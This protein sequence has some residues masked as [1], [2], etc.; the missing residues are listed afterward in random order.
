ME[1]ISIAKM[2]SNYAKQVEKEHRS[3]S[4]YLAEINKDF[5]AYSANIPATTARAKE[6]YSFFAASA[7]KK[8]HLSLVYLKKWYK[9]V[10]SNSQICDYRKIELSEESAAKEKYSGCDFVDMVTYS[11]VLIPVK[12]WSASKVLSKIAAAIKSEREAASA[13]A[14]A[15]REAEKAEKER[16]QMESMRAKLAA[17]DAK[18]AATTATPATPATPAKSSKTAAKSSKATATAS[19]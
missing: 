2:R 14:Q 1:K 16:K 17:Y 5:D 8:E 3:L 9:G 12:L 11:V 7:M 19:A 6:S 13:A 10:D 15:V 18:Q 4:N